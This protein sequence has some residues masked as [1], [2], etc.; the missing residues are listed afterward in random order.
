MLW[1][2]VGRSS[3]YWFLQMFGVLVYYLSVSGFCS[4]VVGG[5]L[6]FL[7]KLEELSK[8]CLRDIVR[9]RLWLV[10]WFLLGA[11]VGIWWENNNTA[12]QRC[13]AKH[14]WSPQTSPN[15]TLSNWLLS[16]VLSTT[17]KYISDW[18]FASPLL[19][20]S[21]IA[22]TYGS[23]EFEPAVF[24]ILKSLCYAMY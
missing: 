19:K 24:F 20:H 21:D 13:G 23:L 14:S 3:T 10:F 18:I 1:K 15:R 16:W 7:F 5:L 12:M 11:A 6:R 8:Q 2:T 17:S 4:Q 9:A 22:E